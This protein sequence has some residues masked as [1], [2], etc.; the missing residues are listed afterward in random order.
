MSYS[1]STRLSAVA[2]PASPQLLRPLPIE[3]LY[4]DLDE[5][6]GDVAGRIEMLVALNAEGVV[7]D[8]EVT[9]PLDPAVDRTAL[10]CVRRWKFEPAIR[11]GR[12]TPVY[13]S[14]FI[15]VNERSL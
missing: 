11:G 2:E 7:H 5:D 9:R 10:E 3:K 13:F 12:P 6:A 8:L 4:P 15:S 14:A 1:C